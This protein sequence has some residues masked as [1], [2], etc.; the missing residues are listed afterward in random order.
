MLQFYDNKYFRPRE[1]GEYYC[2]TETG[3][4]KFLDYSAKYQAWN[5][6]DDP[7]LYDPSVEIKVICWAYKPKTDQILLNM[8]GRED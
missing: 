3:R 2:I 1:S 4:H 8:M 7:D 5:A 6:D